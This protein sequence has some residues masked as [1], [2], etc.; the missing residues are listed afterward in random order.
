MRSANDLKKNILLTDIELELLLSKTQIKVLI[1]SDVHEKFIFHHLLLKK[2]YNID[3][4]MKKLIHFID[5]QY[6]KCYKMT[7][8][9]DKVKNSEDHTTEF[10]LHFNIIN[11]ISYDVIIERDWLQMMNSFVNWIFFNWCYQ[12]KK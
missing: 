12:S 8:L 9:S 3:F 4:F 5:D 11:M 7:E 2:S 1:N 10:S 6:T